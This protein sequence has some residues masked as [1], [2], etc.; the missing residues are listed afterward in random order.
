[1][2]AAYMRTA[3]APLILAIAIGVASPTYAQR[4]DLGGTWVRLDSAVARTTAT[5]GD[6]A[7][8]KGDMGVGWGTPLTI[9]QTATQLDV[10]FDAFTAYDLQPKVRFRF[11]LDGTESRNPV[12][13]GSAPPSRSRAAWRDA[14][15]VI[16]TTYTAPAGVSVTPGAL[17]V[18]Q[19]LALD[20]NGRLTIQSRRLGANGTAN[21]L[22]ATYTRRAN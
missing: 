17:E 4:P 13:M 15:V 11:A 1:L 16:T 8:P 9:V 2:T 7:F 20:A 10:V 14:S 3:F 5:T 12:A 18:Q 6:A 21:T 19:T 22:T